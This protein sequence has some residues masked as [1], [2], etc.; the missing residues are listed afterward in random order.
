MSN[1]TK[2]RNTIQFKPQNLGS[3]DRSLRAIVGFTALITVLV[4]ARSQGMFLGYSPDEFPYFWV[5][6][7]AFYPTLTA[8]L[9]W[10]PFYQVFGIRSET[11]LKGDVSGT[12]PEQTD[13]LIDALDS[14][15][16]PANH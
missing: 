8:M 10:D 11:P 14:K 6:L 15:S 4:A 9:G 3:I 16:R 1:K 12:I 5:S 2:Q 7:I 13:A